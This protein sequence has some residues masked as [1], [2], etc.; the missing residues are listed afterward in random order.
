MAIDSREYI[1]IAAGKGCH[2]PAASDES[3]SVANH[4]STVV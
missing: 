3:S 2:G 1:K 4:D